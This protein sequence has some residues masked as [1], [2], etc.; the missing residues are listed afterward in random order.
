MESVDLDLA[1]ELSNRY[2]NNRFLPDKAIDVMDETGAA[3]RLRPAGKKRKTVGVRDVERH[4]DVD[5]D[6]GLVRVGARAGSLAR[7]ASTDPL[8]TPVVL[9]V[10]ATVAPLELDQLRHALQIIAAYRTLNHLNLARVAADTLFEGS[11]SR[12]EG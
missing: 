8:L 11:G 2:I 6:G 7:S 1:V 12:S 9:F 10:L 3:V 4:G 5:S